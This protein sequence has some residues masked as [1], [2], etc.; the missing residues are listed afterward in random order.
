MRLGRDSFSR[1]WLLLTAAGGFAVTAFGNPVGTDK[2]EFFEKEIRPALV[3][4]CYECHSGEKAKA[5][6]RL[7][8]RGGWTSG[9]ESGPAIVPGDPKASLFLQAIRHEHPDLAMPKGSDPLPVE[10]VEHFERWIAEGAI[11]PRIEPPS[12]VDAA[13]E[14]WKA[15]LR[16]RSRW[17]SLQMP[18]RTEPPVVDDLE[19][20][21]EPVD[22][23]VRSKLDDAGLEPAEPAEA[24]VLLRRLSFV[25]TGLPPD[26]EKVAVF[27]EAF[28]DNPDKATSELVDELLSSPQFG[29]RFARHWMDVVRY[30]DTHG[31]EWDLAAK[32]SWEYRDYLVRA[33]N[34]DVGFDQLVREHLAGDLLAEP[35]IDKSA[36]TNES[37]IGPMFY[38]F[39]ERRHGNSLMFNG[40][41]HDMVDSQIDA[42]SKAFLGMTVACA[43]CHD[44]KLDAISQKD[45]Y[46]L[47]GMFMTPR[48]T[49]RIIDEPGVHGEQIGVLKELREEIRDE[50]TSLWKKEVERGNVTA[51][52]LYD[53]ARDKPK[54]L[55]AITRPVA[56][57]LNTLSWA[58]AENF[59]AESSDPTTSLTLEGDGRTIL[60]SGELPQ[61]DSYTIRFTTPPGEEV[62]LLRLDALTH[63][64]LGSSGPGRTVHGNFVLSSIRVEVTP[65]GTTESVEVPIVSAE[66]DYEQPN[67]PVASALEDSSK[68]WGVGLGGNVDRHAVFHFAKRQ[69][70]PEGGKWKV[71]LDFDLGGGHILG[72]FRVRPGRESAD[73][74]LEDDKVLATWSR[75]AEEWRGEQERRRAHNEA[76]TVLTDFSEPGFPEG[77]ST[78]GEGIQQGYVPDPTLLV[79]LEGDS[80]FSGLLRRGYHTHALSPKLPGAV[81]APHPDKLPRNKTRVQI[82]GGEWA[83]RSAVPQNAFLNEGPL[84][85]DPAAGPLWQPVDIRDSMNNGV[86]RVLT[87]FVTASLHP[88][89]PP[90]TGVAKMGTKVLPNEDDGYDKASWFGI[91][92]I[93][94]DDEGKAPLE[95]LDVFRPLFDGPKPQSAQEVRERLDAWLHGPIERFAD[96]TASD[97]DAGILEM[98]L[99]AGLLSNRKNATDILAQA[100][101]RYR[102]VEATIGFPRSVNSMDENDVVPV[103]YR[104]NVRGDVYEDGPEVA[105]GFLEVFDGLHRIDPRE[106]SGR[107]ELA[108]HLSSG[109]NPQVARVYVNR[110]WQWI[111]GTGLVDT[112]NDFGKLGGRPSHPELLD[113]LALQFIEE[114]WSTRKL[115]RRLVTSR[116]FRQ[117][118][119]VSEM[120]SVKDPSNRL[121]HHYPTRRLEAEAIRD[122]LLA[123]SGRLDPTL[124]GQPIRPHRS[125]EDDKKRLFSGPLDGDG[126]RSL[127]LQMSIMQPPAFLVGFNLPDLKLPNGRRDVTNVPAQALV[128]LNDPFV[129]AMADHW[130][131]RLVADGSANP[132]E[133][134]GS[135]FLEAFGRSA[136]EEEIGL[137]TETL[138][139]FS[140]GPEDIMNDRVAWSEISH[141]LFNAKEFLYYR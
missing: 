92:G 55:D 125:V 29:E 1:R 32:G 33:F 87:D 68:G 97:S 37:L 26:P 75:L 88:N 7:D 49:P 121:L 77:W 113:W 111:F 106:G 78:E 139:D 24:E 110:V 64:T 22:R 89:F 81:R 43:R 99:D 120:A 115:V 108:E 28:R 85:F 74:S 76:F 45:Y 41:H 122:S 109:N 93:V 51:A 46:A 104:L 44:H 98:L 62:S 117:S 16:E 80:A 135:M 34:N 102:E 107:L 61:T 70:L 13:E 3:A 38:H 84:F 2:V 15:K 123:V 90:R 18:K 31:Y 67:Y 65:A 131:E 73:G 69:G 101:E 119:E 128:L 11:D 130:A 138:V 39:G 136:E 127:Y 140:T 63:A 112:P 50:V 54:T 52:A 17:W 60:A 129:I 6:L 118:G 19:W 35:R 21:E 23:F 116:S 59:F 72:R 53:H 12:A 124:G 10:M 14:A 40:I 58:K 9:G 56:E 4:N 95:P 66:A 36:G 47:A 25:L 91:T 30:T 96:R 94:A 134:I 57:L 132:E 48:W 103:D 71:T 5:G 105:R 79:A 82:T 27:P 86:T 100:V 42:F 137:L 8:F 141:T 126:R 133:R 114:N 20:A 83:G